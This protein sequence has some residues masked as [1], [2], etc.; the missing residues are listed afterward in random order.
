MND[1]REQIGAMLT[2]D[3]LEIGPGGSPF[4]TSQ[5]ASVKYVDRSV[6]G[7]RDANWPELV[8]NPPGINADFD[9][10]LDVDGL[11]P[12]AESSFDV[13]IASHLLEHLANPIK[14]I[15]EFERVL[16]PGGKMVLL[17]P[18]RTS[19]FDAVREPT[20]LSHI[21]SEYHENVTEVSDAHLTEFCNAIYKQ[22]PIHPEQVREWHNPDKLDAELFELHR[23]RS[24]HVHCW[25]QEEFA[26]LVVGLLAQGLI[27]F[28]LNDLYFMED[29]HGGWEFGLVL[30]RAPKSALP[31][32]ISI[33]FINEYVS[34][35]M[36]RGCIKREVQIIA[37][38]Q[39]A[40]CRDANEICYLSDLIDVS[41]SQLL[42][43]LSTTGSPWQ[44]I[45]KA[46]RQFL[47]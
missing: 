9:L 47:K 22:D 15:C 14:A 13:I 26:S 17:L 36:K 2:G 42:N 33:N 34:A 19:T 4:P 40:L 3:V 29:S 32:D 39:L 31:K 18:N 5:G 12:I 27:S 23:R 41:A 43:H 21:L 8:G 1:R 37:K 45:V 24:I 10:H 7:G 35:V 28:K 46:V 44:K 30:E 11:S 20:K 16:R 6:Q 25:S 38:L